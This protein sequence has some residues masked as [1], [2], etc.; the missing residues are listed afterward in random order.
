MQAAVAQVVFRPLF[1]PPTTLSA[2]SNL[3]FPN[4]FPYV[5]RCRKLEQEALEGL[6]QHFHDEEWQA[7]QREKTKELERLRQEE[8]EE[9]ERIVDEYREIGMLLKGYPQEEVFKAKK[10]VSS[11]LKSAEEIEE[12]IEEAAERGELDELVLMVI[13]TRL[14][15][16]RR[17][18]EKDAIRS[19]DLLYR[20][21][22][23]EILKRQASPAMR[24][25]NDLLI[26]HDGYD[27]EGWLKACKKRMIETFPREDPFSLLVPAGF[28]L[29]KHHGPLG[30]SAMEADNL[31]LRIDFIRE[32]DTLLKEVKPTETVGSNTEALDPQSVANRLKEQEKKKVIRQV[33]ALLDLAIKLSW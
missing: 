18:E 20:R 31:L 17:D 19:L 8:D 28:D 3:S 7:R 27:D 6:P 14:D 12:K 15:L 29:D 24:L 22:E 32:V 4:K 2:S 25:L 11:F 30:R 10:L 5:C 9:E 16:A 26:M 33:E 1:L 13:W 21:V 23:T